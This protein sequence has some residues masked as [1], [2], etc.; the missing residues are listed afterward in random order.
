MFFF[1]KLISVFYFS[2]SI[3]KTVLFSENLTVNFCLI[4][5]IY[6]NGLG[7]KPSWWCLGTI[8]VK[9]VLLSWILDSRLLVMRRKRR[10]VSSSYPTRVFLNCLHVMKVAA[11]QKR[12][13]LRVKLHCWSFLTLNKNTTD[14]DAWIIQYWSRVISTLKQ[15]NMTESLKGL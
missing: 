13:G 4:H 8:G 2:I 3:Y 5:K 11:W 15:L 6:L 12:V 14:C 10:V 1:F 7:V 9:T